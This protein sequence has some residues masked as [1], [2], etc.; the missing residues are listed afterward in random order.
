MEFTEE[1][2]GTVVIFHMHGK[3]MGGL[4]TQTLCHRLQDLLAANQ[5]FLV[6]DF[7]NVQWINSSGIGAI[8]ACL[9][10]LRARGGD[11]RFAHL[12]GSPLHYFHITKLETV[13]QSYDTVEAAVQSFAAGL[14][15]A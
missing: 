13:T 9:N 10:A 6:M 1:N 4:E 2:S 11:I 14:L 12:Q 8:V 7:Q 15:A 5:R 3:I